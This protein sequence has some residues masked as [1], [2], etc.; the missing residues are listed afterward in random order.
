[1]PMPRTCAGAPAA[2]IPLPDLAATQALGAALAALLSPGD[3]VGLK[4]P[5]GAGKTT[6]ARAV[7]AAL[8]SP[9]E[10]PSPTFT[11][12]QTYDVAKGTVWHFDFYRL[13]TPEEAFELAIEEAFNDGISLIEWPEKIE[14]LLPADRLEVALAILPG[15]EARRARFFPFGRWRERLPELLRRLGEARGKA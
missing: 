9:G 6:L 11:L 5:L 8:G 7:I 14:P 3:V 10:V 2:E 4:G 12:V 15:G 1:M 13:E